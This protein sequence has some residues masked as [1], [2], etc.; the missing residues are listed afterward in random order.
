MYLQIIITNKFQ[1]YQM[2][3]KGMKT[4]IIIISS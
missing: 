2:I 3:E 4:N 1:I